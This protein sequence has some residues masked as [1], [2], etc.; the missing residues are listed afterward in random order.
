MGRTETRGERMEEG[1]KEEERKNWIDKGQGGYGEG[2]R[3]GRRKRQKEE[4]RKN[5]MDRGER[6]GR[7]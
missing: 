4:R 6:V 1:E 3:E 7:G 2:G 5:G